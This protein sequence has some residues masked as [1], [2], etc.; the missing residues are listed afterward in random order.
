MVAHTVHAN[1]FLS[2][3]CTSRI[4][5]RVSAFCTD[6]PAVR[7]TAPPLPFGSTGRLKINLVPRC[8]SHVHGQQKNGQQ[9]QRESQA[10]RAS[11]AAAG[12]GGNEDPLVAAAAAAVAAVSKV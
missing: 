4:E 8:T 2:F 3:E 1:S 10:R 5:K 11:Y 7:Y 9:E 6:A 12:G